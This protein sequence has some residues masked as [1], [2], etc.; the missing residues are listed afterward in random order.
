MPDFARMRASFDDSLRKAR[1]SHTATV[2]DTHGLTM[3]SEAAEELRRHKAADKADKAMLASMEIEAEAIREERRRKKLR[4]AAKRGGDTS[5]PMTYTQELRLSLTEERRTAAQ[6]AEAEEAKR[7]VARA[8]REKRARREITKAVRDSEAERTPA[9]SVCGRARA[10]C[11]NREE[12]R[13]PGKARAC[14]AS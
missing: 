9:D 11:A 4:E 5:V 14:C 3:F 12:K 2:A 7:A 13:V 10:C 6:L 1:R 8:E